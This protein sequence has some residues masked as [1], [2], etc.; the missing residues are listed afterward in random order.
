MWINPHV[1]NIRNQLTKDAA[2]DKDIPVVFDRI[3]KTN[4]YSEHEEEDTFKWHEEWEHC[5]KAAVTKQFFPN[6]RE[7]LPAE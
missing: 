3:P 1:G 5:S 7:G 4:L 6:V 2:S